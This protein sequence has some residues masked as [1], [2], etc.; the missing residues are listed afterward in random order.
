MVCDLANVPRSKLKLRMNSATIRRMVLSRSKVVEMMRGVS[1]ALAT[2]MAT[3]SELNANTR[4]DSVAPNNPCRTFCTTA[5]SM[6]HAQVQLNRSSTK[7]KIRTK[8]NDVMNAATG[9]TH[10]DERR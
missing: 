5:T 8:T 2:W 10:R 9:T 4:N 6:V 1:W 3:S 7:L